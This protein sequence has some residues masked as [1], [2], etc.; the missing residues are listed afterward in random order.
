MSAYRHIFFDLDRTLW[1]FDTN[2]REALL[3]LIAAFRLKE[4]GIE[5]QHGFIA[6]YQKINAHYWSLYRNQNIDKATLRWIRF[7]RTLQMYGIDDRDLAHELAA[8]YIAVSPLKTGLLP[9]AIDTLDHLA[10][11]YR[12]H[13]I[14]NGFEEVQHLKL[15]RSGLEPY[16]DVVVTSERAGCKKPRREIFEHAVSASSAKVEESLMIGDDLETD[17]RGAQ[18]AGMDHVYFNPKSERH[19]VSVT[20]EIRALEELRK[21]L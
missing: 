15:N 1:D 2:S 14:T 18:N 11:R 4:R 3:E 6:A 16:F 7:D 5:D 19:D 8:R 21:L 10:G 9:G 17:I 12:L 20:H 13:I